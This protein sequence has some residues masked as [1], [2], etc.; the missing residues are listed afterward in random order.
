MI[1]G[2]LKVSPGYKDGQCLGQ[3]NGDE[4]PRDQGMVREVNSDIEALE[5]N[6][7]RKGPKRAPRHRGEVC[8]WP[9]HRRDVS[10]NQEAKHFN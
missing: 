1:S 5:Q 3:K 9:V 8:P 10:A 6:S 7:C 2:G 4:G